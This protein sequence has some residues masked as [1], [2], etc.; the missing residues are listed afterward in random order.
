MHKDVRALLRDLERQG[1]TIGMNGSGHST[2][3][4]PDHPRLRITVVNTPH[5]R[6]RWRHNTLRNL[7]NLGGYQ[8]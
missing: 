4:P 7:K 2:A 8:P 6:R 1:W 5:D 3:S